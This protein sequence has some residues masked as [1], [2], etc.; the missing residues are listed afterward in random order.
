MSFQS[1]EDVVLKLPLSCV[2]K[3]PRQDF[4]QHRPLTGTQQLLM[5]PVPSSSARLE[6]VCLHEGL[7][8]SRGWRGSAAAPASLSSSEE[9]QACGVDSW[10]VQQEE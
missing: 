9:M 5:I 4:R 6:R 3:A 8:W 7:L 10:L 2:V 1:S